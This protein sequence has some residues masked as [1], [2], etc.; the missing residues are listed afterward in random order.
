MGEKR[1]KLQNAVKIVHMQ[2]ILNFIFLLLENMKI[3]INSTAF[4]WLRLK[5]RFLAP[6][7]AVVCLDG[8]DQAD[9]IRMFFSFPVLRM[10]E[11][12]CLENKQYNFENVLNT[13]NY[14]NSWNERIVKTFS[15]CFIDLVTFDLFQFLLSAE[16]SKKYLD[17]LFMNRQWIDDI[18][19]KWNFQKEDCTI[20]QLC[21]RHL[22]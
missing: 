11:V 14:L 3:T 13:F 17:K 16:I 19:S 8:F 10:K 20:V 1:G 5:E 4:L 22:D 6:I 7:L 2:L 12:S 18:Q 21:I 9:L 15:F